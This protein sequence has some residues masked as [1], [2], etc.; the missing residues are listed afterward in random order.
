M[1]NLYSI[2]DLKNMGVTIYGKNIKISKFV[3]IYNPINLILHDNI[4]ID[5]FT[6]ISCKGPIEIFSNVHIS[7][8]CFIS[9]TTKIIFGNYTCIS[10]GCRLFG[11][12]DDFSGDYLTNPTIPKKYLKVTEG[13]IILKDHVLVGSNSIILPNVILEEGSSFGCFSLIK[14]NTEAWKVYGGIPIKILKNRSKKCLELQK[15]FEI[16]TENL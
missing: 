16:E 10:V 3:N 9:S 8:Q 7:A 4:R 11:G 12:C 5:D 2:N 1:S 15:E 14:N 6:I 13:D